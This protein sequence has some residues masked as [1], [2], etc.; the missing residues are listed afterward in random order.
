M[1]LLLRLGLAASAAVCLVVA[2]LA[3]PAHTQDKPKPP[4]MS[5]EQQAMMDAMTKAATPGANHKLLAS[6]AGNWTFT[7]KMWMDPAAPP[8]E[9]GGTA[10]Y[11]MILGGRYLQGTAKGVFMGMPFEGMGITAYDNVTKQFVS[12]WIDN[13]GTGM[14]YATGQ[15][16]APTKAITFTGDMDDPTKPG[17][18]IKVREVIRLVD[19]NRHVM[20]WYERRS[21]KDVKTMEIVYTRTK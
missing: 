3:F 13:F 15:Y 5:N 11:A 19:A 21:G 10:S 17:V 2:P 16:D 20:E 4:A 6:L 18:K 7:Q 12:S 1:G 9:S 8:T 14:M